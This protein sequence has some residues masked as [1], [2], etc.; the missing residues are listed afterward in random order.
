MVILRHEFLVLYV[1]HGNFQVYHVIHITTVDLC[2]QII[3]LLILLHVT[4]RFVDK[5]FLIG[6]AIFSRLLQ[7][8]EVFPRCSH[9][10]HDYGINLT[11]IMSF[12]SMILIHYT[13]S[14]K[15][16]VTLS[17]LAVRSLFFSRLFHMIDL[18]SEPNLP[19]L[20]VQWV[21]FIGANFPEW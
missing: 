9:N 5:R 15:P 10:K 7:T 11:P 1:Y 4:N 19:H 13:T 6:F 21:I 20:T 16:K 17:G 8:S 2:N 14:F 18:S 3:T 12:L